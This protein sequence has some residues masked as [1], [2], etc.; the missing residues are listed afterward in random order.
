[1]PSAARSRRPADLLRERAEAVRLAHVRACTTAAVQGSQHPPESQLSAAAVA[2][3]LA[4][5]VAQGTADRQ[6]VF[7]VEGLLRSVE[8]ELGMTRRA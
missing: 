3:L 8:S 1:M 2:T 5:D 7:A 4:A 6:L